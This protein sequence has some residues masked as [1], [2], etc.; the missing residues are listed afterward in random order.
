VRPCRNAV[1]PGM[2][3]LYRAM[4]VRGVHFQY[5]VLPQRRTRAPD[6]LLSN[7]LNLSGNETAPAPTRPHGCGG[8]TGGGGRPE[9][10]W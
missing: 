2:G 9:R 1:S 10:T 4:W 8:Q 3:E 5:V 6:A 7:D